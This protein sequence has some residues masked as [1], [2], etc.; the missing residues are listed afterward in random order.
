MYQGNV[1]VYLTWFIYKIDVNDNLATYVITL[2]IKRAV[3]LHELSTALYS[4]IPK[5][6]CDFF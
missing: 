4:F 5:N 3:T 1:L 6:S 2:F